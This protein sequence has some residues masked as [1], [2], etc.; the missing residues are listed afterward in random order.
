MSIWG[1]PPAKI[2][3]GNTVKI[4]AEMGLQIWAPQRLKI[5]VSAAPGWHEFFQPDQSRFAF[6]LRK[7][8]TM[9]WAR[10]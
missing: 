5:N 4:Q 8:F 10:V 1:Q 9:S 2:H 7:F 3:N 6:A